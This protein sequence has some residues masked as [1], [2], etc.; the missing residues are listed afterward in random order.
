[1]ET[2]KIDGRALLKMT[3]SEVEEVKTAYKHGLAG[4]FYDNRYVYYVSEDGAPLNWHGFNGKAN[5]NVDAPYV[6]CPVHTKEAWEDYEAS[7]ATEP[8]TEEST[9]AHVD[10]D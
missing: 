6:T 8:P 2:V 7:Q 3:P 5:K 9:D 10:P 1:M 4:D